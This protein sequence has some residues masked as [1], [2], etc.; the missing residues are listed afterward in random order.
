MAVCGDRASRIVPTAGDDDSPEQ[1]R[2]Y[3]LNRYFELN[4]QPNKTVYSHF[5][6]ATNT[7]NIK[8]VFRAVRDTILQTNLKNYNLI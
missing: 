1:V 2:M 6:C 3:V 8:F 5:T 4:R 7:N